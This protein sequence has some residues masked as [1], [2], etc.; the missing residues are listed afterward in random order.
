MLPVAHL[1]LS[2]SHCGG[3]LYLDGARRAQVKYLSVLIACLSAA[4]PAR[5]R[6][7]VPVC[8][9]AA[10]PAELLPTRSTHTLRDRPKCPV[11]V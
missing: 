8:A 1:F 7:D 9:F 2:L 4:E 11:C 10:D 6:A 5:E 3:A